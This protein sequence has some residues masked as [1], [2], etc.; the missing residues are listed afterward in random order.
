MSVRVPAVG[1]KPVRKQPI[2]HASYADSSDGYGDSNNP[3]MC[4]LVDKREV[5]AAVLREGLVQSFVDLFYLVHRVDTHVTA[6]G[7]EMK[8]PVAISPAQI[9]FL[10]DHLTAAE[11]A[12]RQGDVIHVF[13]SYE[14]LAVYF[15]DQQDLRTGVFFHEKCLEIARISRNQDFE[16]AALENLGNAYY[17]LKEFHKAKENHELHLALVTQ[18]R[19]AGAHESNRAEAAAMAQLSK[20]YEEVARQ[21]ETKREYD[22][23]IAI[24]AKFL[25]C[26][27]EA[28]DLTNVAAGH[29]RIGCCFNAMNQPTDALVYLKDYLVMCKNLGDTDGECNAYA[30]LATTFEATGH[31]SQ[32]M[33]YL[34]EYLITAEKI[35]N[36]VAQAEAC[37]RLGLLYSAAKDFNLAAEMMERNFD[38]IKNATKSD[39]AL[40]DQARISLGVIRAHQKFHLFVDFVTSDLDGFLKWKASRTIEPKA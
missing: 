38:L 3:A 2:R 31:A 25:Q 35:E 4:S 12:R 30:A 26:A 11:K 7:Q 19:A 8:E 28:K 34:K 1:T 21:H 16:L 20:V 10:R 37:R 9:K 22:Q 36:V 13:E 40:L 23:A 6:D 15:M 29:Y 27:Q 24:H 17:G 33:D 5:C 18:M 32:A 14:K 39:T